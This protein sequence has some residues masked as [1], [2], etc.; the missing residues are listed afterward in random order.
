MKMIIKCIARHL[1]ENVNCF[2][3][4]VNSKIVVGWAS[5][6]YLPNVKQLG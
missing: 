3:L 1:F 6:E 2:K 4:F 5:I